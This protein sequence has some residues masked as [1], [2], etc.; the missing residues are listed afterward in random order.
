[1]LY[2]ALYGLTVIVVILLQ[3]LAAVQQVGLTTLVG[4]REG[5]VLTGLAG[6]MERAANNSLLALALVAPAV[7]ITHLSD[8]ADDLADQLMLT[9]LLSRI[10]Y[11]ALY[12]LG[13]VWF[14][15]VAWI[16]AFVCTA[17]LYVDLIL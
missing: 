15:T 12:A 13:I 7:L 2:L 17:L 9:F 3:V 8:A 1:M 5:L 14:R 16:I 10:A 6:R 11:V 4:N